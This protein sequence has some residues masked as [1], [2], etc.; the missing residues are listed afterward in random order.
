M[1]PVMV[2]E[3]QHPIMKIDISEITK[4]YNF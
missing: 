2:P 3:R 1:D 4:Q